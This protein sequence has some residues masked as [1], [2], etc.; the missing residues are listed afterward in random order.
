MKTKSETLLSRITSSRSEPV[1][2]VLRS[3][4]LRWKQQFPH[5]LK[6]RP[7]CLRL[8]PQPGQL[9]RQLVDPRQGGAQLDRER[10][11]R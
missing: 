8:Q 4:Q 1:D 2:P 3:E 9:L 6:Q 11:E 10:V 5:V 7:V